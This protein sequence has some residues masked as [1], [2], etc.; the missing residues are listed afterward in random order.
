MICV[1]VL[2]GRHYFQFPAIIQSDVTIWLF[3]K[4]ENFRIR[5]GKGFKNQNQKLFAPETLAP[6]MLKYA[7]N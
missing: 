5:R 1:I 4:S 3:C 6:K 7:L 2:F